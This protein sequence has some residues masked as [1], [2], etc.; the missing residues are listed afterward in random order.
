MTNNQA[1]E[2]KNIRKNFLQANQELEIIKGINLEIKKGELALLIGPSGSGKTTIL[3][4]S[5]LLDCPTS[6]EILVNGINASKASDEI[7]TKI[8]RENIGFVYQA[9]HLLPEFSAIENAALPLLIQGNNKDESFKRAEEILK[10]IGLADRLYHKPS[11]LSGGQQ[12]RVAIARAVITKPS[13]ILADEPTGNLDS[14]IAIKVFDLIKD[15]A[16]AHNIGCLMVTH[17]LELGKKSDKIFSIKD[18]IL[19]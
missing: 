10:E 5:G 1:L 13:L 12:Q 16:K 3:Q 8:R 9:H 18:G 4:I 17:N 7:R 15:L 19:A 2:L 11:E 14:E 6:G